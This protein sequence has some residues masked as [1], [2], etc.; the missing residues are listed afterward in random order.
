MPKLEIFSDLSERVVG[1]RSNCGE[2]EPEGL[3]ERLGVRMS[4]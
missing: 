3:L 2:G 1:E 4:A